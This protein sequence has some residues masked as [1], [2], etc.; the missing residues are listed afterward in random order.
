MIDKIRSYISSD[1]YLITAHARLR[2]AERGITTGAIEQAIFTGEIIEEYSDDE[3]CPSVLMGIETT[4][5][6]LHVVIGVCDDHL[7]IITCYYP[8]D[9]HWITY[10]ERRRE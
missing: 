8:D 3:P 10:N 6:M 4:D 5:I 9:T 1:Q 7:R 2:M